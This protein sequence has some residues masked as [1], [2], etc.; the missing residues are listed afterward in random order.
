M[1]RA[2]PVAADQPEEPAVSDGVGGG[3]RRDAG[4]AVGG[5]GGGGDG[6]SE[7]A[8]IDALPARG[9]AAVGACESSAG[10]AGD[11]GAAV[12]GVM[13]S[14]TTLL[15]ARGRGPGPARC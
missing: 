14:G 7:H 11:A 6:R 2:V 8:P 9:S 10:G 4:D 12:A 5:A 15:C 13:T 1:V 3:A